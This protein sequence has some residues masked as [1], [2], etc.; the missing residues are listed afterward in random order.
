MNS[1]RA[2]FH[3]L[4]IG[5]IALAACRRDGAEAKAATKG[6]NGDVARNV[7][8]IGTEN[9][10]TVESG[11]IS[12]GPV[13]SG[14]LTPRNEATIRAEVAGAVLQTYADKGQA[15]A[16]GALLARLDDSAIR[17]SWLSAKSAVSSA[18][19]AAELATRNAERGTTLQAA[20]A[21][22]QRDLET[23]RSAAA[24]AQAQLADARARLALAGKQ[25][26]KTQIRAPFSGVVSDRPVSAGDVVQP[27]GAIIT[28][29]DP[30][31]MKLEGAVPA[32][33]IG[34]LKRGQPVQFQVNGY[35]GKSFTGHIERINPTADPATRQVRVTVSL[36]NSGNTLVGGLFADGRVSSETRTGLTIPVAAVDQRGVRPTVMRVRQGQAEQ[37]AVEL[38]L[39]DEHGERVEV[40]SGVAAGD[41]LLLGAAQGITAGTPVRVVTTNDRAT[42]E[43]PR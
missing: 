31:S 27:G 23:V 7:V 33:A 32:E 24:A 34:S 36:P 40:R 12:S 17:D 4:A 38:G 25:L 19:Q 41:T 22:S 20:G 35:P 29:V 11:E 42:A 43:R 14:T 30:S 9:V 37:V 10:A 5:A 26:E 16:R 2:L 15:V 21:V 1:P 13:L 3:L 18:Q 39:R 6:S 28:V 8:T